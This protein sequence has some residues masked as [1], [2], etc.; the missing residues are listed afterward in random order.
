MSD[1]IAC[2]KATGTNTRCGDYKR[3]VTSRNKVLGM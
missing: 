1:I 3:A 2:V